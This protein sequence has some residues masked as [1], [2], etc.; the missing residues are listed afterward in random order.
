MK[1]LILLF[2]ST[3]SCTHVEEELNAQDQEIISFLEI[4]SLAGNCNQQQRER[5][6]KDAKLKR[7]AKKRIGLV[8]S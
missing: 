8:M 3:S 5:P 1:N 7:I 4:S 2:P 6:K